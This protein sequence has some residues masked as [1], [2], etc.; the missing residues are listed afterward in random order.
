MRYTHFS[1]TIG[2]RPIVVYSVSVRGGPKEKVLVADHYEHNKA[3][4]TC[5]RYSP[6]HCHLDATARNT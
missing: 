4:D 6:S 1:G 5:H 2:D 3:S